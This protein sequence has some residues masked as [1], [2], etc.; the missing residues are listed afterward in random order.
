MYLNG[1]DAMRKNHLTGT[2][3]QNRFALESIQFILR[4]IYQRIKRM[5]YSILSNN[6]RMLIEQYTIK[7]YI[8]KEVDD[9]LRQV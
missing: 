4:N 7:F 1:K 5:F 6:W 2:K 3:E 8:E 9:K